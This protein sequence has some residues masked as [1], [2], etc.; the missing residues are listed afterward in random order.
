MNKYLVAIIGLAACL[1]LVMLGSAPASL[2]WEEAALGYDAYS[3]WKTGKD[4]HGNSWPVVAFESFGDFKPSGYFYLAAPFVGIFGLH[5]WSIRLPSALAGILTVWLVYAIGLEIFK[6]RKMALL[7]AFTLAI[8]PWH[9]QF[10]RAA[11]EVNVATMWLTA[12]IWLLLKARERLGFVFPAGLC[13]VLSMYTYHG[14]RIVAPVIVLFM[15]LT[16][17]K[18]KIL[19]LNVMLAAL[20]CVAI[21]LPILIN[22][23]NPVVAQRF[24]ETSLFST[25][26]AVQVTNE[27]RSQDGNSLL[28]RIIHHRYWYWGKEIISG[29]MSHFSPSFLLL[30]GDLNQRH[31]TGYFGLLYWWTIIPLIYFIKTYRRTDSHFTFLFLLFWI[32]IA[33]LPPALTTISPHTLRFL[34]AAPAFSLLIGYGLGLL[35]TKRR[36]WISI[37]MTMTIST[38]LAIYC[39]DYVTSYVI[40][41]EADWQYGYAQLVHYLQTN[42]PYNEPI[43][44]TRAY[45]RPSIY[46]LFYLTYNP[47]TIQQESR[48]VPK[49]QGELLAFDR[50]T[51]GPIDTSKKGIAVSEQLLSVGNQLTQ[52]M[53]LDNKP[54]FYVYEIK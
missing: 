18:R 31:Q 5:N 50:Y 19:S 17:L 35:L 42:T 2:Y 11:F 39:F 10:S 44:V 32:M 20:F 45:G 24:A 26:N 40:R 14:L 13:F 3:L 12:G 16:F 53:S 21:L 6:E 33:T 8:L 15:G 25:S 1:R 28:S 29:M 22:I 27:L 23:Q 4:F 49:D 46:F 51:F 41:S 30:H 47:T 38:E 37:I 52:I 54:I 7:A 36:W 34:P 43:Q 48:I 9:I